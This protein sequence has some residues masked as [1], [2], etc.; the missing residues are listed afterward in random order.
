MRVLKV[1]KLK[2][3]KIKNV[4]YK[5][6]HSHWQFYIKNSNL[7]LVPCISSVFTFI[8]VSEITSFRFALKQCLFVNKSRENIIE[9]QIP[10]KSAYSVGR[11]VKEL[12]LKPS[13]NSSIACI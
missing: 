10:N 1:K 5:T 8:A 4:C 9:K 3:K 7:F 13:N 2:T 12:T 6:I 11:F